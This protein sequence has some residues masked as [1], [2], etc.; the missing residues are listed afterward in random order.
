MKTVLA[1]GVFDH[2]HPGHQF[3]LQAARELGDRLVVIV[4]RD[5]NVERVKGFLPTHTETERK[6]M[7][8]SLALADTVL[9]GK[10]G[11]NFLAILHE[12]RP[13]IL[14]VGYDQQVPIDFENKFPEISIIKV[15][16]KNPEQWKSS[17]YRNQTSDAA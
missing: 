15:E 9:L 14:A 10:P 2:L 7:V 13:D 8:E 1:T 12:I 17:K 16:P 5:A 4:A 3:Y 11:N 6:A